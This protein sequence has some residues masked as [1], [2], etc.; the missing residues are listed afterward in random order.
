MYSTGINFLA[1]PAGVVP[2]GLVESLPA[3]I[4]VVGRRYRED[5]ILN[6]METIESRVGVLTRQLWAREA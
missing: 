4:Q 2:I 6:A 1:L 3:G 5:L